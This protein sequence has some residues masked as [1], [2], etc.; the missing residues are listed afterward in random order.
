MPTLAASTWKLRRKNSPYLNQP[1]MPRF[2]VTDVS[3]QAR[4][5]HGLGASAMR[6]AAHQSTTVA[7]HSR[8][9]SGG[10]HAA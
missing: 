5:R 8:M 3:I 7:I 4:R 1:S 10:F 6:L 9:M 2:A